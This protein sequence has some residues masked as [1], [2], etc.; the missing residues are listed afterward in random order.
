MGRCFERR[1]TKKRWFFTWG[2]MVYIYIFRE[3][4][5]LGG[6]TIYKYIC[7]YIYIYIYVYVLIYYIEIYRCLLFSYTIFFYDLKQSR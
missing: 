6:V 5:V 7:I 2:L 1:N 3:W 4:S